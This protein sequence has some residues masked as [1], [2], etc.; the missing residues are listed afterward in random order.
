VNPWPARRQRAQALR[1]THPFA[2]ELLT[3]YLALVEVQE[4]AWSAAREAAPAD[5]CAWAAD[6]VLPAVIDATVAAGPAAL[7]AAVSEG[8]DEDALNGWLDGA[9][10]EPVDRYLARASLS[11]VLEA[12]GWE[13]G[14][15]GGGGE[16]CPRCGGPP[17][18]AYLAA[19]GEALVTG[20]R[21]LICA[22]CATSWSC[23]RSACPACGE[24]DDA[25][26]VVYAEGGDAVFPHLR[27][28]GCTTCSRYLIDVDT[29][30]DANAV[31][32]VDEL[33]A[34]PLDLY[35]ADQG[36]TKLTA[37]LMGF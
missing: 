1:A 17:Q 3:L 20:R 29:E 9:E 26:L 32:E 30:R 13:R 24:R 25:K 36:L 12:L 6:R 16:R 33:A 28:A 35:A 10:L 15:N 18:V 23:S 19:S 11:P 37:N 4:H 21:G 27:V 14:G 7:G 5:P 31:P 8:A 22:R 34:L 2:A